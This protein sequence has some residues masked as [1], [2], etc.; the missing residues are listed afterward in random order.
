MYNHY[1]LYQ[2]S[3]T[4]SN[5]IHPQQNQNF[6]ADITRPHPITSLYPTIPRPEPII[7]PYSNSQ[8]SHILTNPYNRSI[9]ETTYTNANI[10]QKSFPRT[11]P[12]IISITS[13][14]KHI[15]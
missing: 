5:I 14:I 6:D 9:Q 10:Q 2:T 4:R 1:Q 8:R 13:I 7:N 12:Y 11:N 3:S 15:C